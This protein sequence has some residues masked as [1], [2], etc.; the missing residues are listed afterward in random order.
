MLSVTY[1]SVLFLFKIVGA[2]NPDLQQT[3]ELRRGKSEDDGRG[4]RT[5]VQQQ[6]VVEDATGFIIP[7]LLDKGLLEPSPEGRGFSLG[8]LLRVVKVS[9]YCCL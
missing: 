4:K 9:A 1:I 3:L 6:S 2:C 5:S 7:L 8:L